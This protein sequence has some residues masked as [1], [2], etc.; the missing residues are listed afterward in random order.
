MRA[1]GGEVGLWGHFVFLADLF[2]K[3]E[4]VYGAV[5]PINILRGREST[6]VRRFIFSKW[7]PRYVL[8]CSRNYG[9]SEW[10]EYRDILLLASKRPAQERD[11]VKFC[12]VKKDLTL[13]T[14][15]D[16]GQIVETVKA[17]DHLRSDVL[18]IDTYTLDQIRPR[19]INLMWFCSTSDFAHRDVISQLH[20]KFASALG[21]YEARYF[22]EGY[23]PVPAGVSKFL[24][25][26]R[27]VGPARVEEAFLR[28]RK[29]GA[30]SVKATTELGVGYEIERESVTT[31]LR[32]PVGLKT[33]DITG[34]HD[35]IATRQYAEFV[36][37]KRASGY[38]KAV[39]EAFWRKLRAELAATETCVVVNRRINPYSPNTHLTAFVSSEP[40]SPSNQVNVVVEKDPELARAFCVVLN[41]FVFWTQFFLLK[42]E[43]TGRFIDI[44]FY[45]L[46]EME[47]KPDGSQI[48]AL[49]RVFDEYKTKP[50]PSLREQMDVNFDQRY[51]EF[52]EA[53]RPTR[54][55]RFW[56]V[57]ERPIEPSPTR[58]A[59]DLAV[60]NAL[61]V[62]VG[63]P[64]LR[65]LY[66][67]IVD[68]MMITRSLSPD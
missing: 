16:V 22:R 54:Q 44:R 15:D 59:F 60:A 41:S 35:Y 21:R 27:E 56:P 42:E 24:F 65:G 11:K 4:G 39:T 58:I 55:A 10:S 9:F 26:T 7:T 13:V 3:Q 48:P 49:L 62:A 50:F 14:P 53:Q 32:T 25:L 68:E 2:L 34:L 19:F 38:K 20:D 46:A 12:L 17:E 30:A 51:E 67:A 61:G 1:A 36:R 47:L 29:D 8:K 33:M 40:F 66:R 43:S 37:V 18:D 28:F 5:I 64:D 57:L 23:R 6:A 45:D 31:S 52:W 63:E